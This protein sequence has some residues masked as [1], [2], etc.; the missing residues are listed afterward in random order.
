M[1]WFFLV[2]LWS[3]FI[4]AAPIFP[5]ARKGNWAKVKELISKEQA[6]V[7]ERNIDGKRIL[8]L[9]A[10][11]GQTEIV[12]MLLNHPQN[13][14]KDVHI[15]ASVLYAVMFKHVATMECLLNRLKGESLENAIGKALVLAV[16]NANNESV[17][18][19]LLNRDASEKIK[20]ERA[21]VIL[22]YSVENKYQDSAEVIKQWLVD[23]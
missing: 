1:K 19:C 13:T 2:F 23:S 15:H 8:Y 16:A 18:L 20:L 7:N 12:N 11:E 5:L 21:L 4:E 6:D 9:A 22:K 3:L 10:E 14:Y 17:I